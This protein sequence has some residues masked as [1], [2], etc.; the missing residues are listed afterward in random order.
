MAENVARGRPS[1]VS[2]QGTEA[3]PDNPPDRRAGKR[4]PGRLGGGLQLELP[5]AG[6]EPRQ[7]RSRGGHVAPEPRRREGREG[8]QERSRLPADEEQPPAGDAGLLPGGRELL[9]RC[10]QLPGAG[11]RARLE[12]G[13]CGSDPAFELRDVPR[14]HHVGVDREDPGVAAIDGTK[15]R[16]LD[17]PVH[18]LRHEQRR[19]GLVAEAHGAANER[20]RGRP[21][22]VPEQ[23]GRGKPARSDS[24]QGESGDIRNLPLPTDLKHLAS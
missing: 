18:A 12:L 17:E 1:P 3:E 10:L 15:L 5:A 22:E 23:S 20:A 14:M 2:H 16:Q 19:Q 11:D 7:P 9:E 21:E 24:D 13:T 4:E 8:E 6:A